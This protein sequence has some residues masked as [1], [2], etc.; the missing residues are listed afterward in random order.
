MPRVFSFV[1]PRFF[2]CVVGSYVVAKTP[3]FSTPY[4]CRLIELVFLGG[5]GAFFIFFIL[6][7][8]DYMYMPGFN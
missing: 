3:T 5:N 6:A 1:H 8:I 4:V 2:I 7:Y